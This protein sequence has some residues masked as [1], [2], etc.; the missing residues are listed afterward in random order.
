M[1]DK[2]FNK[3]FIVFID[4]PDPYKTPEKYDRFISEDSFSIVCS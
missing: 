4:I 3:C 2:A 1:C